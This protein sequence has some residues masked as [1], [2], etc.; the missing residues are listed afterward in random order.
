MSRSHIVER[1]QRKEIEECFV[2]AIFQ[3][4]SLFHVLYT[5]YGQ[6]RTRKSFC[7]RFPE[8]ADDTIIEATVATLRVL[9]L[10]RTM[11]ARRIKPIERVVLEIAFRAIRSLVHLAR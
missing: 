9:S 6:C 1:N 4:Y 8:P 5:Y 2:S 3:I 11:D 7:D 10:E